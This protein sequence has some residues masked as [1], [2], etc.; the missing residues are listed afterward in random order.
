LFLA[1]ALS[2]GTE[3]ILVSEILSL[4]NILFRDAARTT[5]VAAGDTLFWD[6]VSETWLASHPDAEIIHDE[7]GG[8]TDG[9]AG[10]TQFSMLAGRAGGQAIIGGTAA[11]ENLTLESTAHA[12]KGKILVKDSFQAF[13]DAAYSSGWAGTDLG[14][15]GNRFRHVYTAG[16]FFGLR[17]EN[18][19]ILPAAS[20]Q[21]V[22]RLV[23]LTTEKKVYVDDGLHMHQVG[24]SFRYEEDL[25]WDG[26]Q[27][28]YTVTV[29]TEGM[30]ARHAKWSLHDNTNGFE[31]IFGKIRATAADT[32]QIDVNIPLPTGTYRIIGLE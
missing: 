18:V 19:G 17:V 21:R 10:H 23:F 4:R 25:V 6:A 13:T 9:D 20:S 24:D 14:G 12:T 28:G 5:P 27:T 26:L 31:Q 29:T 2:D 16:E 1:D 22:G 15:S 7:I 11:S 32:V 8:L 30:D 3:E